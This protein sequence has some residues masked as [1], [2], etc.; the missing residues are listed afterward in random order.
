MVEVVLGTLNHV[1]LKGCAVVAAG[2]AQTVEFVDALVVGNPVG[3]LGT[4]EQLHVGRKNRL[5]KV[6]VD[7]GVDGSGVYHIGHTH[8]TAD[9]A[10]HAEFAQQRV[11]T[12]SQVGSLLVVG[13]GNGLGGVGL[14]VAKGQTLVLCRSSLSRGSLGSGLSSAVGRSG[15]AIGQTAVELL[16]VGCDF[17]RGVGLPELEVG[18]TLQEFAHTLGIF[19]TRH[20]HHDAA[21]LAFEHLYVGLYHTKLVDTVGDDVLGICHCL[22]HFVAENALHLAVAAVG[23]HFRK[24]LGSE[25]FREPMTRGIG[26]VVFDEQ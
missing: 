6:G 11:L 16:Q 2:H 24:L 20:F 21:F 8:D 18:A 15:L 4:P 22:R 5:G 14:V 23:L 1:A 13:L 9:I 19:H 25:N 7:E 26:L 17:L 3:G 12:G 10:V